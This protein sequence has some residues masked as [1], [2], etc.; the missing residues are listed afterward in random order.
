MPW[1]PFTRGRR[2]KP[3][4]VSDS[5]TEWNSRETSRKPNQDK[6]R[7]GNWSPA[8]R[9]PAGAVEHTAGS[10]H[11]G[12][13]EL[14]TPERGQ[15]ELNCGGL[16]CADAELCRR[17]GKPSPFSGHVPLRGPPRRGWLVQNRAVARGK[18][19][20]TG[21]LVSTTGAGWGNT[22][23]SGQLWP[24]P[25]GE[26]GH[27]RRAGSKLGLH[28]T[29]AEIFIQGARAATSIPPPRSDEEAEPEREEKRRELPAQKLG[30][31]T[32]PIE[33][34]GVHVDPKSRVS[35]VQK[36]GLT[37]LIE[38]PGVHVDPNSRGTC[39]PPKLNLPFWPTIHRV[40]LPWPDLH[41]GGTRA[42]VL[43]PP[44]R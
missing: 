25:H 35:P 26:D 4:A 34:P 20:F 10:E 23:E 27:G 42:I 17:A 1:K 29:H 24:P 18:L 19:D 2:T 6:T 21:R 37:G 12:T 16:D 41:I 31:Q 9:G 8:P 30:L 33:K 32:G 43:P 14:G 5:E 44:P 38:K 3:E 22:K 15:G 40:G 28:L 13:V 36:F 39:T 7:G 11:N